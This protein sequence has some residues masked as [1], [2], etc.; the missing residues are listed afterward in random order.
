M[1]LPLDHVLRT[2]LPWRQD[3]QLTECGLQADSYPTITRDQLFVRAREYGQ[4]RTAMTTCITC[5]NTTQRWRTWNDDPVEA[6][7]RET[8]GGRHGHPR[9]RSE[10]LAIAALIEAHRDEFDSFIAGLDDVTDLAIV[11]QT[12]AQRARQRTGRGGL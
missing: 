12:K 2:N 7:G 9:F 6:I 8:Y 10:L 11:R 1:T 4:Q 5:L 3:D